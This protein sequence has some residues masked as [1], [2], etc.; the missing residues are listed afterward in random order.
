MFITARYLPVN[1][2][3]NLGKCGQNTGSRKIMF[4]KALDIKNS[5]TERTADRDGK[6]WSRNDAADRGYRP[7]RYFTMRSR[8]SFLPS[9][10]QCNNFRI[11]SALKAAAAM[12]AFYPSE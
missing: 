1:A 7:S 2:D 4:K 3:E 8:Y 12:S 6:Y 5:G 9:S 11:A 10:S